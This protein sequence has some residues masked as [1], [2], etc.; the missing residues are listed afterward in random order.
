MSEFK[1]VRTGGTVPD[2]AK[3]ANTPSA[4]S[5]VRNWTV[6]PGAALRPPP[7]M[8]DV[9]PNMFMVLKSIQPDGGR[10]RVSTLLSAKAV[11]SQALSFR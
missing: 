3:H 2:C 9:F 10:Y 7:H 5:Y 11:N 4:S 8:S 6:L 1:A